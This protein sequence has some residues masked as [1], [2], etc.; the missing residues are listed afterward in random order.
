MTRV[1]CLQ[2]APQPTFESATQAALARFEEAVGQGAEALFLPEYAAGFRVD[3]GRFAPPSAEEGTNPYVA[4]MRSAAREH[5]VWAHAG[6]F[7]T[8][9]PSGK[10]RNRSVVIDPEGE[11]VARYDK[12]HLFDIQLSEREV[13]R[14]SDVVAAGDAA[15]VVDAGWCTLGCSICYDVR[16]PGLYEAMAV[17]GATVMAI[18]AAFTRATGA[19]HWHALC[20]ARA[21][22]NGAWVIAAC[23]VGDIDGGGGCYGHSLIID[24]WGTIVADGG[25]SPGVITADIDMAAAVEARNRIPRLTHVRPFRVQ[26]HKT[27]SV[28]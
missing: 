19:V 3:A 17:D 11:I 25:D 10:V 6:S 7:A 4:A 27:G 9:A 18:P 12:V 23:S 1:A 15:C 5:G 8:P 16:F 20:R 13:Y 14:E 2:V 28:V 26:H 22:E 24:P 21:I